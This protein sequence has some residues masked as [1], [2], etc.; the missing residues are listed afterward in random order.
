[1]KTDGCFQLSSP[2]PLPVKIGFHC[3]QMTRSPQRQLDPVLQ[4][5]SLD[6]FALLMKGGRGHRDINHHGNADV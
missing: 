5:M 2:P 1:M 3:S 4:P 6:L